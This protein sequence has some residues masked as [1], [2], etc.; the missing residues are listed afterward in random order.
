MFNYYYG[1]GGGIGSVK[2]DPVPSNLGPAIV[3]EGG[4]F[5]FVAG[6]L[7]IEC[8]LDLPILISL[9]IRPEIGVFG[10]NNFKD[11]FDFDIALG[12]RYQF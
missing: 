7:G 8:N 4:S 12:V 5:G 1:F 6:D 10:Y 9:D 2:F 3:P 11:R